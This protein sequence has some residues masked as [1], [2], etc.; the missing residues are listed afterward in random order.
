MG[1]VQNRHLDGH[2]LYSACTSTQYVTKDQCSCLVWSFLSLPLTR[3]WSLCWPR[4]TAVYDTSYRI[5]VPLRTDEFR[6]LQEQIEL[7]DLPPIGIAQKLKDS[8]RIDYET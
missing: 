4:L 5:V 7:G 3:T 8:G 1:T 6:F 2:I